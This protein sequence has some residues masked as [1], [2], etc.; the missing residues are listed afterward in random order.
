VVCYI[1]NTHQTILIIL[2]GNNYGV[3]AIINLFNFSCPFAIISLNLLRDYKEE[4]DAFSSIICS[5]KKA[6]MVSI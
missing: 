1:F 2:E 3:C 4:N 6:T 5:I